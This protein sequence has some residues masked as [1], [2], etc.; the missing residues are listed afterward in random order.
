MRET[1]L[2]SAIGLGGVFAIPVWRATRGQQD[3][4]APEVIAGLLGVLTIAA[5]LAVAAFDPNTISPLV[6]AHPSVSSLDRSVAWYALVQ[7]LAFGGLLLGV[8]VGR[9]LGLPRPFDFEFD[10]RPHRHLVAGGVAFLVG[11]IAMVVLLRQ[12]G[13]VDFLM[14]ELHRRAARGAGLGYI[15]ALSVYLSVG[16]VLLIHSLRWRRTP[17]RYALVIAAAVAAFILHASTGGRKDSLHLAIL[18]LMTWHFGVSPIRRPVRTLALAIVA[19]WPFFVGVSAVRQPG[20]VRAL[21]ENPI[22]ATRLMNERGRA[23][24]LGVSYVDHHLLATS[25]FD[26]DNLWLG[27]SYL[28]LLTAPVPSSAMVGKPPVDD[29]VYLR[30][31]ASGRHVVPPMSRDQLFSSSW[32]PETLGIGY[33]NFWVPGAVLGM[34][35]LGIIQGVAFRWVRESRGGAFYIIVYGFAVLNLHLSNLRLVQTV[36]SLTLLSAFFL[37]FFYPRNLRPRGV[38]RATEAGR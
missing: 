4:F 5:Y 20:A 13:G 25:H 29:G 6:R 15:S 22:E 16:V 30:T 28:D 9:R 26:I 19:T 23:A 37:L 8:R 24:L 7:A 27:R 32:P 34:L 33:M 18:G 3:P 31:I 10:A 21:V 14:N 36:V 1:I 17:A 11:T 38:V 2:L 12:M 35:I